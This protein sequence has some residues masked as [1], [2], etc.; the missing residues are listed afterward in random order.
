MA[1][2]AWIEAMQEELHQFD[3]LDVWELVDRPLYKY[4][5]NI[6]WLW[7]NKRDEENT[8][9]RNKSHLVAKGYSQQEGIDFEESFSLM[10]VKTS[11][12]NGPLKEEVYVNQPDG[13]VDP[14]HLDKVY[15]LKKALHG[16]KQVGMV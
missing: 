8:V 9:I 14:H 3:Q 15:H 5:T 1:D 4:I 16:L 7:K 10:D 12:L 2:S 11:F 13:F 6:K